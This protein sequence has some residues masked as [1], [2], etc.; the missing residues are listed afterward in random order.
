MFA[1]AVK[2]KEEVDRTSA[3]TKFTKPQSKTDDFNSS[4]MRN[5]SKYSKIT[6]W[7]FFMICRCLV[8][9]HILS[10]PNHPDAVNVK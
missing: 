3:L 2:K 8:L 5:K 7:I 1:T 4:K 6:E 10:V 9:N